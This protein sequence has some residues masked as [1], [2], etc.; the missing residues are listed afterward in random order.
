MYHNNQLMATRLYEILDDL[1]L[2]DD[3]GNISIDKLL[4][5]QQKY[6]LVMNILANLPETEFQTV[7]KLNKNFE[8][9]KE[10]THVMQDFSYKEQRFKLMLERTIELGFSLGYTNINLYNTFIAIFNDVEKR[11]IPHNLET[12]LEILTDTLFTIYTTIEVFNLTDTIY[13]AM[14]EVYTSKMTKLIPNEESSIATLKKSVKALRDKGIEVVTLNLKNNNLMYDRTTGK[15]LNPV[16]YIKPNLKTII[17]KH[18][19]T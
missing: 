7:L 5:P 16:T 3:K 2:V 4:N 1:T 17:Y 12:V 19:K 18:L 13:E 11:E 10:C 15:Q 8:T 9:L 6:N 14:K